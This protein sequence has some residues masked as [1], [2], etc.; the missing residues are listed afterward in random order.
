MAEFPSKN[1]EDSE[2]A[3]GLLF[4]RTYNKWHGEIKK[5]LKLLGITHPQFVILASLGYLLQSGG[6]VTQIM[7]AKMAGMDGMTVSQIVHL[8]EKKQF[9]VR[10][11]H[12]RDTRAKAV[13]LTA[14]GRDI[15]EQALPVVEAIDIRFFGSLGE[16]EG[17]FVSLLHELNRWPD[18]KE[19]AG[20]KMEA[21]F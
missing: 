6:E 1:R 15:L 13:T 3:T 18:G 2:K 16:N 11:E 5:Q 12:S 14:R 10:R 8:L 4:M 7:I 17:L 20:Q 9:I 21:P 19:A